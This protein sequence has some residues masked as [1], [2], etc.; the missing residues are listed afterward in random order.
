[1][2]VNSKIVLA[3]AAGA[4]LA[5]GIVFVALKPSAPPVRVAAVAPPAPAAKPAPSVAEPASAPAPAPEPESPPSVSP[6]SVGDAPHAVPAPQHAAHPPAQVARAAPPPD[7]VPASVRTDQNPSL[8]PAPA[9]QTAEPP[10]PAPASEP[11]PAPE[12]AAAPEP[13]RGQTTP[14]RP[15]QSPA[16]TERSGW[17]SE[18]L[19]RASTEEPPAPARPV[20]DLAPKGLAPTTAAT[21]PLDGLSLDV[22]RMVDPEAAAEAWDRYRRGEPN[23]FS[24]RIY[25]GRGAQTAEEVRRRYR[26]NPDF[27]ATVDRYVQEFER[28]LTE[29]TRDNADQS[30]LRNYLISETGLVYTMLAHAS[31][32]LG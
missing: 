13:R 16:A 26:Q 23:A 22:A 18:L 15:T 30:V 11:A 21:Q 27:H 12:P 25:I 17:L 2:I 4:M 3:F 31:G 6:K 10:V 32:R 29:L 19:A 1:M 14:P 5:S 20:R 9:P 7:D 24:S 28:L 8:A